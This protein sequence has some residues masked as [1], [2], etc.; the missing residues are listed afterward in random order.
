M[1]DPWNA[2]V[3]TEGTVQIHVPKLAVFDTGP[4]IAARDAVSAGNDSAIEV[5][6]S[7]ILTQAKRTVVL[8]RVVEDRAANSG[9]GD[10]AVRLLL[11][12]TC[13]CGYC[14]VN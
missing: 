8:K 4:R 11:L 5:A 2:G 14:C 3:S 12:E 13:F 1:R 6:A 9:S 10:L 7:P